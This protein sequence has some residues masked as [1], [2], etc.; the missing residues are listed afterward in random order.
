MNGSDHARTGSAIAALTRVGILLFAGWT[1]WLFQ[2][3]YRVTQ[4]SE[5]RFSTAWEERLQALAFL[6]FPP[7]I[8]LFA[9]AATA[10]ASATWLAGPTQTLGLAVLL[11][12]LRWTANA[13]VV[14][15]ALSI[16]VELFGQ[17]AG[18]DTIET[19]AFRLG[20]LVALVGLSYLCLAAG[21]TAPGG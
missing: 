9:L 15:A 16:L 8:S 7:N 4:L 12:S 14:V 18:I 19:V 1:L 10:A 3:M 5:S 2:V 20:G 6:T 21:R 17:P 11:R 13:L